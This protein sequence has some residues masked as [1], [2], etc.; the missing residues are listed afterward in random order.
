MIS[1]PKV[2]PA[3]KAAHPFFQTTSFLSRL[4]RQQQRNTYMDMHYKYG[5]NELISGGKLITNMKLLDNSY[6]HGYAR[7]SMKHCEM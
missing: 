2:G 5:L 1:G 3:A 7:M 4:K 6:E